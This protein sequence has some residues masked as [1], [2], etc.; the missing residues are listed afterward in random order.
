MPSYSPNAFTLEEAHA[1][2]ASGGFK[3]TQLGIG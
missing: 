3:P 1:A 2:A